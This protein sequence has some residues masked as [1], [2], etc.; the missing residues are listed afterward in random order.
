MTTEAHLSHPNMPSFE[1]V[2]DIV[3]VGC[4]VSSIAVAYQ[5][6]K[7]LPDYKL[8]ILEGRDSI[9]GT[10]DFF[11]FPGVRI[12]SDVYTYGF[13]WRPYTKQD[14][15]AP[16]SSILEYLRESVAE[17]GIDSKVRFRHKVQDAHWSSDQQLWTLNVD[18]SGQPCTINTRFIFWGTGY[19]NYD[20]PLENAIPG[21]ESFKGNVLHPQY[22]PETA[23]CTGKNVV[24]VGSGATAVTIVPALSKVASHVTMLQR[25]PSYIAA[26]PMNDP[27]VKFMY[28]G[29]PSKIFPLWFTS[30]LVRFKFWASGFFLYAF[31]IAFPDTARGMLK[32][33]TTAELPKHIQHDPHFQPSY[34][35]WTQRLCLVPDGD[36]FQAMREERVSVVTD[37]IDHIDAKGFQLSSGKHL[38]ADTIV[39]ATGLQ[40]RYLGG[41][42][43]DIDHEPLKIHEKF[44]WN[45]CLI[46]DVPNAAL[47]IGYTNQSWT[48]AAEA[49]ATLLCRVLKNMRQQG[50]TSVRPRVENPQQLPTK[51]VLN[52]S[53]TYVTRNLDK[54]PKVSDRRPWRQRASWFSD[55]WD[56]R[57]GS[58][59]KGLEYERAVTS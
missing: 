34:G 16:G 3:L 29:W 39:T 4:G 42:Q 31:C 20:E 19:Y 21:I 15:Y 50:L 1:D 52:L 11:R 58:I 46:Q 10:W 57:F 27:F 24:V 45:N 49:T 7:Q 32:K 2:Y 17:N 8:L 35:P 55:Y 43:V 59:S 44:L 25:S 26:L 54:T 5:I 18:G 53:S 22:W 48:L 40:L 38:E 51:R 6:Q 9:G 13:S 30:M 33:M 23:D 41:T 37:T 56:A 47:N 12:D 14:V 36:F 28:T